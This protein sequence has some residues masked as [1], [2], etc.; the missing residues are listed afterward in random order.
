MLTRTEERVKDIIARALGPAVL[1]F[2]T[3]VG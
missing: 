3:G 2:F 1:H